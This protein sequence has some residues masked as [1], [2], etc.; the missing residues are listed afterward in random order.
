M[1][2]GRG[3]ARR[4][5]ASVVGHRCRIDAHMVGRRVL[6][7]A[8]GGDVRAPLA[9]RLRDAVHAVHHTAVAAEDDRP[10]QIG[11]VHQAYMLDDGA[12]RGQLVAVFKP[13]VF[14]QLGN[15]GQRHG[16]HGQPA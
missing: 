16:L 11:C 6:R 14:V 7:K 13:L 15:V 2:Q 4:A 12:R 10:A 3:A 8:H 5:C 9:Q 1:H